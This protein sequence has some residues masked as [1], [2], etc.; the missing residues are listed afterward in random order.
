MRYLIVM[1]L[2]VAVAGRASA[3]YPQQPY[4]GGRGQYGYGSSMATGSSTGRGST[5]TT[6]CRTSITRRTSRSAR[7]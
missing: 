6:S 2:G 1:V 3:Q 4:P 7:T 5:R